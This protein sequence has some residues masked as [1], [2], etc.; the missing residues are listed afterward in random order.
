MPERDAEQDQPDQRSPRGA[1]HEVDVD[2]LVVLEHERDP[3]RDQQ[4]EDDDPQVEAR[5]PLAA[6]SFLRLGSLL[7]LGRGCRLASAPARPA[8][9]GSLGGGAIAERC[10]RPR[11]QPGLSR[12]DERAAAVEPEGRARFSEHERAQRRPMEIAVLAS[13]FSRLAHAPV[14]SS[15]SPAPNTAGS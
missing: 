9:R 7:L 14:C 5:L 12:R 1:E 13:W 3:V 8:R 15:R 11:H 6:E 10:Q 4:A 2:V